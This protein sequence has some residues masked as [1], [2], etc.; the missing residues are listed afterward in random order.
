MKKIETL[1]VTDRVHARMQPEIF[2]AFKTTAVKLMG[3][4]KLGFDFFVF[5]PYMAKEIGCEQHNEELL[6]IA[7]ILDSDI[8]ET[9]VDIRKNLKPESCFLDDLGVYRRSNPESSLAKLYNSLEALVKKFNFIILEST[10][11]TVIH[12]I[13][14]NPEV[15]D[16]VELGY[17]HKEDVI[18][19]I[20][21]LMIVDLAIKYKKPVFGTCH[22]AQLAYLHAGG[23]LKRIFD[24]G[25]QI[26]QKAYFPRKNPHK[27]PD[28]IWQINKM[29]NTRDLE[30]SRSY[31]M[32][33]YPLPDIFKR[34]SEINTEKYIN[35][36]FNHTLAM[37]IPVPPNIDI[38]L[39]HPLSKNTTSSNEDKYEIKDDLSKYPQ[40]S[41]ES[42][43]LFKSS[44]RKNIII[45][46]FKYESIL[47]FQ[48]HPHYT[49]DDVD[50]AEI[51]EYIVKYILEM[52]RL[53]P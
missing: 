3:K 36:D 24:E 11:V 26:T 49:Y 16:Q 23:T 12:P 18:D 53:V 2:Y 34:Q 25:F 20:Y 38:H 33:K 51:F 22:G 31:S 46:A 14:Y 19:T 8:V 30:D 7:E 47:G 10:I 17:A 9:I 35:R 52:N 5:N 40:I 39:Y 28:E 44:I 21:G 42:I 48:H 13:F 6:E 45:D 1:V 27:G 37:T 15:I 29:L 32:I 50:T 41:K 43:E 4:N